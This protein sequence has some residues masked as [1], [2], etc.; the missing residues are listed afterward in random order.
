MI[1]FQSVECLLQL[2]Q[3]TKRIANDPFIDPFINDFLKRRFFVSTVPT[4]TKNELP[5]TTSKQKRKLEA[6][7][8]CINL[9]L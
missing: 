8:G 1:Y 5:M 7:Q 6:S 4:T 3:F 2:I 9:S